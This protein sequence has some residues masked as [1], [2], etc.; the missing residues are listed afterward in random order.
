[1]RN[2]KIWQYSFPSIQLEGWAEIILREDGFFAAVS[3]YGN[4]AHL[5]P[6]HGCADFRRFFLRVNTFYLVSKLNPKLQVNSEASFKE[7]KAYV[8][9]QRLDRRMDRKEAREIWEH[10]AKFHVRDWELFLADM[11]TALY[12]PTPLDFQ[13]MEQAS[14]T[15]AFVEKVIHARLVP[16]LKQQLDE[17]QSKENHVE[18]VEE[19]VL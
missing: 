14:E 15:V 13:V 9:R 7:V 3:D 6:S 16:V 2:K 8:E 12:F 18:L 19:S 11:D 5:W 4:Y 10:L 17:E 1:M